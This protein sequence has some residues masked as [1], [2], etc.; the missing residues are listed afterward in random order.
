MGNAS[1]EDNSTLPDDSKVVDSELDQGAP[2][3][4]HATPTCHELCLLHGAQVTAGLGWMCS[5]SHELASFPL[6]WLLALLWWPEN[7]LAQHLDLKVH[8]RVPHVLAEECKLC[9]CY[10]S[11]LSSSEMVMRPRQWR[12]RWMSWVWAV[13]PWS[14]REKYDM[15]WGT[16]PGPMLFQVP[17]SKELVWDK[18]GI[19]LEKPLCW[20]GQ[21]RSPDIPR[22]CG[23][24]TR[25]SVTWGLGFNSHFKRVQD[26]RTPQANF[27]ANGFILPVAQLT[28]TAKRKGNWEKKMEIFSLKPTKAYEASA[29]YDFTFQHWR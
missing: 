23:R 22:V 24:K 9:Q 28:Q 4:C 13:D 7:R 15:V 8:I 29:Y 12:A 2:K 14:S 10:I 20:S 11:C 1:P 6:S 25:F 19:P 18:N 21:G 26:D 3:P 16:E 17:P 5:G 27:R